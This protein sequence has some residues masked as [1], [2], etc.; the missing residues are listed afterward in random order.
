M[1]PDARFER[2]DQPDFDFD[3]DFDAD[4]D[5]DADAGPH[6]P[7]RRAVER[8]FRATLPCAHRAADVSLGTGAERE[9]SNRAA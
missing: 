3:F 1:R 5:A 7:A 2:D 8:V 9:D 6:R 4:A